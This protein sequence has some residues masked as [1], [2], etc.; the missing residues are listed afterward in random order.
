M[1]RHEVGLLN[2]QLSVLHIS[3]ILISIQVNT[4]IAFEMDQYPRF[5]ELCGP[6]SAITTPVGGTPVVLVKGA[7]FFRAPLKP[8]QLLPTSFRLAGCNDAV[9]SCL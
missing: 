6:Y 7:G 2:R 4:K 9:K 8:H 1:I 5:P 3:H